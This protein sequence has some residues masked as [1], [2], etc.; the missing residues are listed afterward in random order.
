MTC[1]GSFE[2]LPRARTLP[3]FKRITI[4]FGWPKAADE[5]IAEGKGHDAPARISNGLERCV[6][7]M[8]ASGTSEGSSP[9]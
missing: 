8:L 4:E 9:A 2:A 7:D 3:R 1:H 5:L 6:K